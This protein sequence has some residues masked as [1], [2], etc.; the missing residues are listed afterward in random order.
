MKKGPETGLFSC[1]SKQ[2]PLARGGDAAAVRAAAGDG[3][4]RAGQQRRGRGG[5]AAV[6]AVQRDGGYFKPAGKQAGLIVK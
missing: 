5:E 6:P 1:C 4:L 3:Y 2:R